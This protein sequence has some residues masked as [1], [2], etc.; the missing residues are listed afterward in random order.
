MFYDTVEIAAIKI[1]VSNVESLGIYSKDALIK[2]IV[3][4]TE[5][6]EFL[7]KLLI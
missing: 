7:E 6:Y 5:K 3:W 2:S 4:L 1:A